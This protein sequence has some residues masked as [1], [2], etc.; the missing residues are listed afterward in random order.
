LVG[1]RALYGEGPQLSLSTLRINQRSISISD[2]RKRKFLAIS[3]IELKVSGNE[4]LRD[5]NLEGSKKRIHKAATV[6]AE[7]V[8]SFSVEVDSK[9]RSIRY[10]TTGCAKTAAEACQKAETLA[11]RILR[12]VRELHGTNTRGEI[13]EGERIRDLFMDIIGGD[14]EILF[15]RSNI[16]VRREERTNSSSGFLLMRVTDGSIGILNVRKIISIIRD[17]GIDVTYVIHL[18]ANRA[19]DENALIDGIERCQMWL[20]SPFFI[21]NGRDVAV[22]KEK[23]NMLKGGIEGL[24]RGGV[25]KIERGSTTLDRVG[26]ILFRSLEGRKLPLSND[27]LINHVLTQ[28]PGLEAHQQ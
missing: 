23:V 9:T 19:Y 16:V 15:R 5:D 21:V 3:F 6:L 22:I 18:T 4:I 20:A 14:F 27:Q 1:E 2:C 17:L 7:H 25:L 10:V 13:I 26:E 28:S 11:E 8:R 12:I 24:T